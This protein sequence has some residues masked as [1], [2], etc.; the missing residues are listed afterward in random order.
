MKSFCQFC[1]EQEQE[2]LDEGLIRS[3]AILAYASKAR[4]EGQQ[5]EKAFRR[6]I[7]ELSTRKP[8][9]SV[10]T[11]LERMEYALKALLNGLTHQRKQISNAGAVDV[12]GHLL[13]SKALMKMARADRKR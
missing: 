7:A 12:A 4:A 11:R 2:Q 9:D 8:A 5:S 10:E 13:T 3:G 1:E 6:G